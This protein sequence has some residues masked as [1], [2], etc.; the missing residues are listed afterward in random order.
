MILRTLAPGPSF[1]ANDF[2]RS[3]IFL[4]NAFFKYV[5]HHDNIAERPLRVFLSRKTAAQHYKH[6]PH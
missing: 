5:T 1:T 6:I 2:V 4:V 3:I